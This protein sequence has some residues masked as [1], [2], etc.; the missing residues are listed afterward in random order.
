VKK[1]DSSVSDRTREDLL[2]R[3]DAGTATVDEMLE[4]HEKRREAIRET[5]VDPCA[6]KEAKG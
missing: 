6:P 1:P 2:E 5:G 4:H 3:R